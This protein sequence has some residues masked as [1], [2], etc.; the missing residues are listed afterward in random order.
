M[1]EATFITMAIVGIAIAIA[2]SKLKPKPNQKAKTCADYCNS[3]FPCDYTCGEG[4]KP[5]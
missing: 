2:K 4:S 1:N 5:S 3:T